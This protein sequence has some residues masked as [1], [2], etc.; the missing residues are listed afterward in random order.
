MTAK[1]YFCGKKRKDIAEANRELSDADVKKNA[2]KAFKALSVEEK[3]EWEAKETEGKKEWRQELTDLGFPLE[4]TK[5][6]ASRQPPST[7]VP[8][9]PARWL[10]STFRIPCISRQTMLP[11]RSMIMGKESASLTTRRALRRATLSGKLG[12]MPAWPRPRHPLPHPPRQPLCRPPQHSPCHPLDQRCRQRPHHPT[13][14][15]KWTLRN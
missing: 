4:T 15:L 9:T 13:R 5:V 7:G 10:A 1:D 8:R 2:N 12:Q 11:R 6:C 3:Q 14:L